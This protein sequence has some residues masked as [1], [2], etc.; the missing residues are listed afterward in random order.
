MDFL[1]IKGLATFGWV[2]KNVASIWIMY[3]V[4]PLLMPTVSWGLSP[5]MSTPAP[6]QK[7][8]RSLCAGVA[9]AVLDRRLLIRLAAS[10][11]IIAVAAIDLF[12][13]HREGLHSITM[14]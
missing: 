4:V 5:Y 13:S 3:A 11:T 9:A 10:T 14:S 6:H 1:G 12:W 8:S 2:G 7:G